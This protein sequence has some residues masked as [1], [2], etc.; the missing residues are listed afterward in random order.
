MEAN[1]AL[2]SNRCK[3]KIS[4]NWTIIIITNGLGRLVVVRKNNKTMLFLTLISYV[5]VL[6]QIVFIT[7]AIGKLNIYYSHHNLTF[8]LF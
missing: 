5:A 1:K 2:K 3:F 7:I 6:I 8:V 4:M